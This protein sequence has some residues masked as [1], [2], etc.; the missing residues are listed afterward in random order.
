MYEES[1]NGLKHVY[2]MSKIVVQD[3]VVVGSSTGL[4]EFRE[5]I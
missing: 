5:I 3:E 4:K 2:N 1:E